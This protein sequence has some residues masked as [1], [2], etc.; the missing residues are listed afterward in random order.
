MV[1]RSSDGKARQIDCYESGGGSINRKWDRQR[2]C[3]FKK[4]V[5]FIEHDGAMYWLRMSPGY[6]EHNGYW[7]IGCWFPGESDVARRLIGSAFSTLQALAKRGKVE[8]WTK[9]LSSLQ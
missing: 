9:T 4:K 1:F 8:E 7:S 6:P 5:L 3:L 2:R